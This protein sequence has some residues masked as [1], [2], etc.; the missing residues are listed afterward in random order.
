MSL[1]IGLLAFP[2]SEALQ[3]EVRSGSWQA[4]CF[5]RS[6]VRAPAHVA[7]R[8]RERCDRHD[9]IAD[10]RSADACPR[11]SPSV[12]VAGV[13]SEDDVAGGE[14]GSLK[15]VRVRMFSAVE[16]EPQVA[17]AVSESSAF[18]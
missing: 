2:T 13:S 9:L 15:S 10:D 16:G 3:D 6:R 11:S 4:R 18:T 14:V 5:P 1:F 7:I 12:R 17:P 8:I